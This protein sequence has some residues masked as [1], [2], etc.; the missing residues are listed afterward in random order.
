M[1][2]LLFALIFIHLICLVFPTT[3]NFQEKFLHVE[4]N[5]FSETNKP[6]IINNRDLLETRHTRNR[7]GLSSAL[8]FQN[9]SPKNITVK[10]VKKSLFLFLFIRQRRERKRKKAASSL[11]FPTENT[12]F[13]LHFQSRYRVIFLLS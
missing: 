2:K 7:R 8:P 3:H 1:Q 13:L 12:F 10:V 11:F 5:D 6:L 9:D 4:E